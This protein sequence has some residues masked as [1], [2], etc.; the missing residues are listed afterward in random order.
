MCQAASANPPPR[1]LVVAGILHPRL[2]SAILSPDLRGPI[3]RR[4]VLEPTGPLYGRTVGTV[5]LHCP[6][7][8]K[9][10]Q[11]DGA[12][13]GAITP[14]PHCGQVFQIPAPVVRL[15]Q[16][17]LSA[18]RRRG[19]YGAPC[20]PSPR[21]VGVVIAVGMGVF[22]FAVLMLVILKTIFPSRA[23]TR[24]SESQYFQKQENEQARNAQYEREFWNLPDAR[25]LFVGV[26]ANGTVLYLQLSQE[27]S[28]A[29]GSSLKDATYAIALHFGKFHDG[30][31]SVH[32]RN[33]V[34]REVAIATRTLLGDLEVTLK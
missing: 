34:G 33:Y 5:D 6:R 11:A 16:L 32:V 28:L 9:A 25:R 27:G 19:R 31:V 14:C 23:A 24:I 8:G 10:C 13:G 7:C 15:R 29:S 22:V 17:P 21:S 4:M 2:L 18:R 20:R 12:T 3:I 30:F 26:R 1:P